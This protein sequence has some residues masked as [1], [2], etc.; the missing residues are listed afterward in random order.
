MNDYSKASQKKMAFAIVN[1]G[2]LY[3]TSYVK[4]I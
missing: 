4:N 1:S 2:V 3:N